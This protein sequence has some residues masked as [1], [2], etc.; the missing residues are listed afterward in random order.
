MDLLVDLVV[1]KNVE[2][3]LQNKF[4]P[5]S[6]LEVEEAM[7]NFDGKLIEDDRSNNK[8][9]PPTY[10]FISETAHG[11][12][13]KIVLKIDTKNNVAYLRTAYEPDEKEIMYYED[14]C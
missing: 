2:E 11:R 14:H 9:I 4:H 5:V 7:F 13:L 8:T 12:L 6:I 3:K 10:W 1:T